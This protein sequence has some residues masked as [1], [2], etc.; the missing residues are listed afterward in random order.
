M[1]FVFAETEKGHILFQKH[2]SPMLSQH[3]VL[4]LVT[5]LKARFQQ[6]CTG[7]FPSQLL[8]FCFHLNTGKE[9]WRLRAMLSILTVS[10][11]SKRRAPELT[12]S[13]SS[14]PC[15]K[16]PRPLTLVALALVW[17][18]LPLHPPLLQWAVGIW[19]ASYCFLKLVPYSLLIESLT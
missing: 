6:F 2:T 9:A 17:P 7:S 1:S 18:D 12:L 15:Q 13:R 4:F 5:V 3:P 14:G 16:P 8:L 11:T 10:G 19:P